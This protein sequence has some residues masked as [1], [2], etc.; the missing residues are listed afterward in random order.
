MAENISTCSENSK[1]V[2]SRQGTETTWGL[3]YFKR[4]VGVGPENNS[5]F[6][7]GGVGGG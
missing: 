6:G 1:K 3:F 5:E 7:G 2:L 4:V